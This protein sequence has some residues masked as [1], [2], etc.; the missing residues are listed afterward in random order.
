[1]SSSVLEHAR[2]L[3]FYSSVSSLKF[4]MRSF[5][6]AQPLIQ[7]TYYTYADG[8]LSPQGLGTYA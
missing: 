8:R 2:A 4:M 7:D 5:L 3:A 6:D 1:M